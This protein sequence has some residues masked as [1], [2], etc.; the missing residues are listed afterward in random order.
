MQKIIEV[1]LKCGMA[2]DNGLQREL[3]GLKDLKQMIFFCEPRPTNKIEVLCSARV[4]ETIFDN[5]SPEPSLS[6]KS[7]SLSRLSNISRPISSLKNKT[8]VLHS[9]QDEES[10]ID[11]SLPGPSSLKP[12]R[13]TTANTSRP[14]S[15]LDNVAS[16][17]FVETSP[18]INVSSH[19]RN[20][21]V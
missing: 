1:V 14:I 4:E 21:S 20:N 5:P 6:C 16:Y 12:P 7:S 10:T 11:D 2:T 8:K 15:A 3:N 18:H 17:I 19:E 9:A 13:L